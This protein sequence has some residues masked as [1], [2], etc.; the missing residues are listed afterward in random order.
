MPGALRFPLVAGGVDQSTDACLGPIGI[1]AAGRGSGAGKILLGL[2]LQLLLAKN[3]ERVCIDWTNAYNYYKPL[4]LPAV[5]KY[6]SA[7]KDF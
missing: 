5:R 3:A 2:S 6:W 4:N 1:A 7:V